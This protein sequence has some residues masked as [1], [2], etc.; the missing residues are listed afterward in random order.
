[1][2]CIHKAS[3]NLWSAQLQCSLLRRKRAIL[4]FGGGMKGKGGS[5][6]SAWLTHFITVTIHNYHKLYF[7]P[8][9]SWKRANAE[10]RY[11]RECHGWG[12]IT[13]TVTAVIWQGEEGGCG[14]WC[15]WTSTHTHM[16][17]HTHT[18]NRGT[19][20]SVRI[21]VLHPR[22]FCPTKMWNSP[23]FHFK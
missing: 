5:A 4:A 22:A 9:F 2:G 14:V 13:V 18:S 10:L 15:P 23:L 7:F 19:H 3:L 8:L 11:G 17:T 20:G 6:Y 21:Q 1:M 16:H 12:D